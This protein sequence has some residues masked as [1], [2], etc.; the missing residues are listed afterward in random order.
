MPIISRNYKFVILLHSTPT[1]TP[2]PPVSFAPFKFPTSTAEEIKR[3]SIPDNKK[4]GA[5]KS[6]VIL[7]GHHNAFATTLLITV[8]SGGNDIFDVVR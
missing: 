2:T 8:F 1:P 5:D 6:Q 3:K 7:K 4:L